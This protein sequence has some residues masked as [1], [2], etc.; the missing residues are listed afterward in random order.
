MTLCSEN[1]EYWRHQFYLSLLLHPINTF[2]YFNTGEIEPRSAIVLFNFASWP[3]ARLDPIDTLD[4]HA[5]IQESG[6]LRINV[7][8]K[9]YLKKFPKYEKYFNDA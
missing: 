7:G 5:L 3:K 8:F 4:I 6:G 1:E 2:A 9:E